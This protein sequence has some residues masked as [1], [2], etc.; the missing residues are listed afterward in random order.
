MSP[1]DLHRH[2]W[3]ACPRRGRIVVENPDTT[4][5]DRYALVVLIVVAAMAA[6]GGLHRVR[7]GSERRI[8]HPGARGVLRRGRMMA[9]KSSILPLR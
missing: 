8:H 1:V 4:R 7:G 2:L 6:R 3:P 9:G 5:G